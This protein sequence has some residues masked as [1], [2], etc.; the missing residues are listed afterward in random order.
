MDMFMGGSETTA[1]SLL[2]A[3]AFLIHHPEIQVKNQF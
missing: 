2:W 1:T 3:V